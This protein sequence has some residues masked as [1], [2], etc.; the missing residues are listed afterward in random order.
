[1]LVRYPARRSRSRAGARLLETIGAV[2]CGRG[3]QRGVEDRHLAA[4]RR[5]VRHGLAALTIG[6]YQLGDGPPPLRD[7]DFATLSNL[8]EKSRE[9]GWQPPGRSRARMRAPSRFTRRCYTRAERARERARRYPAL[10]SV[11]ARDCVRFG[12][13]QPRL[14]PLRPLPRRSP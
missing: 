2:P 8:V 12:R 14:V 11:A 13:C 6:R 5:Q 3:G 1:G 9:V 4:E 7:D 10:R